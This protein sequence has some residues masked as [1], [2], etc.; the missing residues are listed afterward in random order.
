M[1]SCVPF[2]CWMSGLGT[3]SY[4]SIRFIYD[5][6]TV[7]STRKVHFTYGCI[8]TAQYGLTCSL[9]VYAPVNILPA[10][11]GGGGG[12]TQGNLTS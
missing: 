4:D 12:L 10:R 1:K 2:G 6:D 8:Y 5:I 9:K 11:G 7:D 3:V